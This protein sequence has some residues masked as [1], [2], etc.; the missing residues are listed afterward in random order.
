MSRYGRSLPFDESSSTHA[1]RIIIRPVTER[2]RDQSD[3]IIIESVP[4]A[5]GY[6]YTQTRCSENGSRRALTSGRTHQAVDERSWQDT[7]MYSAAIREFVSDNERHVT[8]DDITRWMHGNGQIWVSDRK[9]LSCHLSI[10]YMGCITYALLRETYHETSSADRTTYIESPSTAITGSSVFTSIV[11]YCRSLNCVK[12]RSYQEKLKSCGREIC[13][14]LAGV[15][16]PDYIRR[17][18]ELI[19]HVAKASPCRDRYERVDSSHNSDLWSLIYEE[20]KT[21]IR[22]AIS[23]KERAE[24][25][26][27]PKGTETV[28]T[29]GI[30]QRGEDNLESTSVSRD[31]VSGDTRSDRPIY[32]TS[33]YRISQKSLR[34]ENG[35]IYVWCERELIALGTHTACARRIA[36][37]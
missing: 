11:M 16:C 28:P 13:K 1:E 31:Q 2:T 7:H 19:G 22:T 17:E 12:H 30:A 21:D 23:E 6:I 24:K 29:Q 35:R 3:S 5:L 33:I 10:Y 4:M 26:G 25:E 32:R 8:T 14:Y 37:T 34:R 18:R 36:E 27:I 15:R 9:C 20:S